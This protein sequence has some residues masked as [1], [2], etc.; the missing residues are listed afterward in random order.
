MKKTLYFS[1]IFLFISYLSV[2]QKIALKGILTDSSGK[3][4]ES[5]TVLL[6]SGKDSSMVSF[7]RSTAE[8]KFSIPGL[9]ANL[10]LLKITY[11]GMK[12]FNR[13]LDLK[14]QTD[15]ELGTLRMEAINKQLNEVL[16]LGDKA[17]IALK[18]DTIEY[19]AGSFKTQP[20]AVVEDLLKRLPG[21][22]VQ[23]DGTIKAQGQEVKRVLV[24]GKEFFGRDPKMATKNLPA[25]AVDKVQVFD[26]KSDQAEFSGID[27]G[28]R[29]K[30]INLALKEDKK[31]GVFGTASAGMGLDKRYSGRLNVNRFSKNRQLSLLGMG[32]NVNQQGFSIN[33]YLNFSGGLSNMMQGGMVRLEIGSSNSSG[34]GGGVPLNNGGQVNGFMKNW[35]GG[36]NI[37][38]QFS[39]KTELNGSYFYNN[40]NATTE[41]ESTRQNFLPDRSFTTSQNS[42]SENR[43]QNHRLNFTLDHKIDSMQNLR[44]NA[45]VTYN[46]TNTYTS[47]L[48]HSVNDKGLT[49][50]EGERLNTGESGGWNV[51]S[52]LLYRRRFQKKGRNLS[53][54]FTFGLNNT[55]QKV[56]LNAINSYFN[57]TG[58]RFRSDTIRQNQTQDNQRYNTGINLSYT[59]PLGGRK[60]LETNYSYRLTHNDA[61]RDVFDLGKGDSPTR[62]LNGLLTNHFRSDF[63]Y[64]RGGLNFRFNTKKSNLTTGLSLQHAQL[65][66][67]LITK[68]TSISRTFTNLLPS[69]NF[70]YDFSSSNRLDF[71][72]ETNVQE[73]SIQQ[74][75]PI[76]DNSD[77]LNIYVG[78]DQLRPE[79]GH[80]LSLN[81]SAFNQLAF[82]NFFASVFFNYTHNKITNAQNIDQLLVRTTKPINV[83]YDYMGNIY[84]N[85]GFRIK[86]L[87][88]RISLSPSL[89]YNRG[90]TY[91]N[92]ELNRTDRWMP[93]ADLRFDY[94]YK[95]LIDF[96]F[97]GKLSYNET[98]YSISKTLNQ[99]FV[100]R[101]YFADLSLNLPKNWR[102]IN[103][104]NYFV[105]SGLSI[106][107]DQTLPLWGAS[108]AKSFLKN[109]RGELKLSVTDLLNRNVGI[110]RRAEL[111]YVE[112]E[113]I[114]SLGR[115]FLLTFT[116]AI[117]GF[118]SGLP[119]GGGINIIRQ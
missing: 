92:A 55:D 71:R 72:Y 12:E 87:K 27:D 31:K 36:A 39:K 104:F 100:N 33:D 19:N 74:L 110:N 119:P 38:N 113:R 94:R 68:K 58:N 45:Y 17:P 96:G 15:G 43:N 35:A 66:G 52:N 6:L 84:L 57:S 41:R 23:R 81:Y 18:G 60:Y 91:I 70:H 78:N 46:H 105:Y 7:T 115:Y 79:Y 34:S 62:T 30:T 26:K 63:Q 59:E 47:S 9:N 112:N 56:N 67:D 5:A 16:V 61:N 11:V 28:Q 21:V 8:G 65:D 40:L 88:T 97:G 2:A 49:E 86:P 4:L 102:L 98:K 13:K 108:V 44:L 54:T 103:E 107:Q 75:A 69:V 83:D 116:Y 82:T 80:R 106:G 10:Y 77:P 73:P 93:S 24:D 42:L 114:R 1:F 99:S 90:I 37:N 25:D 48:S 76:V 3:A 111:N 32:N 64:H 51:N 118:G 101:S 109:K 22:E 89:T 117:K 95:E 53:A 85:Y 29:D 20:N 14:A 50:N